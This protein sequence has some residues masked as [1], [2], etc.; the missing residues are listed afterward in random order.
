M[1]NN[2]KIDFAINTINNIEGI[3]SNILENY[4]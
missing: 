4:P 3:K 1:F 2:K